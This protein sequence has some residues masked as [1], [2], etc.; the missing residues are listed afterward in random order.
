MTYR[1]GAVVSSEK[2]P[3]SSS[4]DGAV[5]AIR[6]ALEFAAARD[7]LALAAAVHAM[8]L[9][10]GVFLAEGGGREAAG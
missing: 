2:E 10:L 9:A 3:Q 1:S 7:P 4:R 5:T 6:R 8:E